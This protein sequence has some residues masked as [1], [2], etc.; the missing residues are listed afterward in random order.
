MSDIQF[1]FTQKQQQILYIVAGALWLIGII[2]L[3]NFNGL[4]ILSFAVISLFLILATQYKGKIKMWV[5]IGIIAT[6]LLWT[7][8]SYLEHIDP[9][10]KGN[11]S[12]QEWWQVGVIVILVGVFWLSQRVVERISR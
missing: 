4:T 8:L 10:E 7:Y 1:N 5:N 11:E 3:W 9:V 2:I 6:G 12:V